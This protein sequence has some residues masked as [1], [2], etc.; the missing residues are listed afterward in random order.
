MKKR[1]DKKTQMYREPP[2]KIKRAHERKDRQINGLLRKT[3]K[4]LSTFHAV[5]L[6]R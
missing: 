2:M 5:L 4:M 6:W 1:R 3:P